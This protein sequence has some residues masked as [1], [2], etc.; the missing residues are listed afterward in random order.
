[1]RGAPYFCRA[2]A[3]AVDTRGQLPMG[4]INLSTIF[5]DKVVH[6]PVQKSISH[7]RKSFF[8][9]STKKYAQAFAMSIQALAPD[10]RVDAASAG[11]RRDGFVNAVD[12][13]GRRIAI[14]ETRAKD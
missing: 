3:T 7:P 8:R 10:P 13:S 12:E 4:P 11:D 5:V 14:L 2:A 1:L 9:F 6:K